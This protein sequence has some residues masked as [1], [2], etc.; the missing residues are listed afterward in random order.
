[1]QTGQEAASVVAPYE[2]VSSAEE[3]E[4]AKAKGIRFIQ[5]ACAGKDPGT[6]PR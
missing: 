5:L 4:A 1:M 2:A 6:D 3:I